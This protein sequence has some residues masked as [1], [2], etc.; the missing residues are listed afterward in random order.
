MNFGDERLPARFWNK[1]APCPMTGCWLWIA[2]T[3]PNGYGQVDGYATSRYPHRVTLSVAAGPLIPGLEV[4]HLCR[5][6]SCCNPAHLEQVTRSVNV[7][8]GATGQRRACPRGHEYTPENTY[9]QKKPGRKHGAVSRTCRACCREKKQ[10][11]RDAG[12]K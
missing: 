8:R 10:R 2:G 6:R 1:V 4:D 3:N 7:Q 11:A 5:V 12:R 9:M